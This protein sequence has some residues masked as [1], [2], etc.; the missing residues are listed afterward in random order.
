[1]GE[2]EIKMQTTKTLKAEIFIFNFLPA[3]GTPRRWSLDDFEIM[4]G[5][6]KHVFRAYYCTKIIL[7][8]TPT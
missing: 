8:G 6:S 5:I 4:G 1:M 7:D 3:H 2:V